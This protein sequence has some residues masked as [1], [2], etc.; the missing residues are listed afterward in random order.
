MAA[1]TAP[2]GGLVAGLKIGVTQ[3]GAPLTVGR[4]APHT[5]VLGG[6]GLL[7]GRLDVLA[8]GGQLGVKGFLDLL[9]AAGGLAEVVVAGLQVLHPGGQ[10]VVLGLQTVRVPVAEAFGALR[11]SFLGLVLRA[12][13]LGRGTGLRQPALHGPGGGCKALHPHV[14][15]GGV[16]AVVVGVTHQFVVGALIEFDVHVPLGAANLLARRQVTTLVVVVE[17]LRQV[18]D[19]RGPVQFVLRGLVGS[20]LRLFGADLLPLGVPFLAS[21]PLVLALVGALPALEAVVFP[22][23]NLVLDAAPVLTILGDD[24]DVLVTVGS[25]PQHLLGLAVLLYGVPDLIVLDDAPSCGE[26]VRA[27]DAILGLEVAGQA[28]TVPPVGLD[29]VH[30]V[31]RR[32]ILGP[33]VEC[34]VGVGDGLEVR[35]VGGVHRL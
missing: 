22:G 13:G 21:N 35:V 8:L 20:F 33:V 16:V 6:L 3:V 28:L 27:A 1:G 9:A 34:F 25:G 17:L 26:V 14:R 12:V 7:V 2:Q 5:E 11:G 15:R 18:V 24:D 32:P 31:R 19:L 30:D 23:K 4:L 10:G 29:T